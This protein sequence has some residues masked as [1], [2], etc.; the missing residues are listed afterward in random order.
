MWQIESTSQAHTAKEGAVVL[1]QA[2]AIIA[3]AEVIL[4][5]FLIVHR[6]QVQLGH[7]EF[8]NNIKHKAQY[9][10]ISLHQK[11]A[12]QLVLPLLFIF[13]TKKSLMLNSRQISAS[14]ASIY[15]CVIL[16]KLHTGWFTGYLP[17]IY[18]C[19]SSI[20]NKGLVNSLIF[21]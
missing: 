14:S 9:A 4:D 2:L 5:F 8:Y 7:P 21:F 20:V 6:G 18:I 12:F 3:H 13:F 17:N 10:M 15:L 11:N 19:H 16:T 1:R